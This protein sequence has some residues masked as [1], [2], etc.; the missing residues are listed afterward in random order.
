MG[1]GPVGSD[2]SIDEGGWQIEYG[3]EAR[4][5]HEIFEAE[6]VKTGAACRMKAFLPHCTGELGPTDERRT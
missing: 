2:L 6:L 1:G 3:Q 4:E 5:V